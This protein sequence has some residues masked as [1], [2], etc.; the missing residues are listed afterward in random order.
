MCSVAALEGVSAV[1]NSPN[2]GDR[3]RASLQPFVASWN[4]GVLPV[5]LRAVAQIFVATVGTYL[6]SRATSNVL[7]PVVS[8][9]YA[10]LEEKLRTLTN[11]CQALDVLTQ[12]PDDPF[13]R[14]LLVQAVLD[15][16]EQD[17]QFEGELRG[18]ITRLRAITNPQG[19]TGESALSQ[20]GINTARFTQS[21]TS[22]SGLL[23][24][25]ACTDQPRWSAWLPI[26]WLI[27]IGA[28]VLV[29]LCSCTV[30]YAIASPYL[31]L[32]ESARVARV[33]GHWTG[34]NDGGG[35]IVLVI[36]ADGS[37]HL[38][39]AGWPCSVEVGSPAWNEYVLTADC[40]I[41][42]GQMDVALSDVDNTLTLTD[43]TI[44]DEPTVLYRA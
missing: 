19:N 36:R 37:G 21:T 8:E 18:W 33:E 14:T 3:S 39:S 31:G 23:A 11:G 25:R 38:N 5:E 32:T 22:M 20:G 29:V 30:V 44:A 10:W 15:R 41:V 42:R 6:A 17:E 12:D 13:A 4:Q 2:F 26:G 16:A 43:P 7:D 40:G 27:A 1:T 28:A 35:K 24:G 34:S 9:A